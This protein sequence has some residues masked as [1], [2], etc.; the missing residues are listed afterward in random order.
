MKLIYVLCTVV[1]LAS[2]IRNHYGFNKVAEVYLPDS[3]LHLEI[4]LSLS[5]LK[6]VREKTLKLRC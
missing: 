6:E 4:N 2:C 5:T 1:H 3:Y